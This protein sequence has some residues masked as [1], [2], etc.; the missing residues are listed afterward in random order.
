MDSNISKC[1]ATLEGHSDYV[2][3]II[4]LSDKRIASCSSD[5]TIKIWDSI[6]FKCLATIRGHSDYVNF[7]IELSEHNEIQISKWVPKFYFIEIKT[8]LNVIPGDRPLTSNVLLQLK[9][10]HSKVKA[11]DD[12]LELEEEEEEE[13]SWRFIMTSQLF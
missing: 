1:L 4:E 7:I 13:T 8:D 3:C 10:A 9:F 11:G 5:K 6:T 12:E 2:N